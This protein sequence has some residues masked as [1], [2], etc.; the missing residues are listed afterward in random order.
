[1]K[2]STFNFVDSDSV[3]SSLFSIFKLIPG[4]IYFYN[5]DSNIVANLIKQS[6]LPFSLFFV[7]TAVH[8]AVVTGR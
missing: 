3:S 2:N 4:S 5:L 7:Y 8:F 1:M 6:F